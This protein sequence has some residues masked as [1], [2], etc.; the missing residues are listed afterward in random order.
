ML[1]CSWLNKSWIQPN[2]TLTSIKAGKSLLK[3]LDSFTYQAVHSGNPWIST[4]HVRVVACS[5]QTLQRAQKSWTVN[6]SLRS[7]TFCQPR[8]KMFSCLLRLLMPKSRSMYLEIVS[9][10]SLIKSMAI[11]SALKRIGEAVRYQECKLQKIQTGLV[12]SDDKR[13]LDKGSFVKMHRCSYL[14]L[15]GCTRGQKSF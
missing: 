15:M 14:R 1:A 5:R 13:T 8:I 3:S 12:W 11:T 4:R 7:S 10:S 6:W 2:K 9:F